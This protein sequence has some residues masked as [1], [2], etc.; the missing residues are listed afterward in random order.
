MRKIQEN[1]LKI[2]KVRKATTEINRG[3]SQIMP[4][5]MGNGAKYHQNMTIKEKEI[6]QKARCNI[7][8]LKNSKQKS[9]ESRIGSQDDKDNKLL[10][11]DVKRDAKSKT[12]EG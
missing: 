6:K 9:P 2:Q 10:L 3:Y 8:G 1:V 7:H 12:I 4:I 11:L 5:A